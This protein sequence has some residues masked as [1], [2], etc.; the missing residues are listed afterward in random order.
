MPR[1][2]ISALVA[3]A[4]ATLPDNNTGLIAPADV[5]NLIIDFLDTISPA[6]AVMA[7]QPPATL[8]K[9]LTTTDSV[10]FFAS[11][12]AVTPADF[13]VDFATGNITKLNPGT[14]RFSFTVDISLA[15]NRQVTFT[16]YVNGVA[17]PWAVSNQGDGTGNLQSLS[18]SGLFYLNEPNAVF[19]IFARGSAA[20]NVTL[21]NAA[22]VCENVPVNIFT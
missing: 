6:Y 11:N 19:Q 13:T 1:R 3:Q 16:L 9:A 4:V 15:S 17:T 21:S 2:A 18:M 22:F 8:N 10:V 20:T 12:G 7:I 14:T 5:R